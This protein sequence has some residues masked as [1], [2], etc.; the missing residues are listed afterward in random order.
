MSWTAAAR[1]PGCVTHLGSEQAPGAREGYRLEGA[2]TSYLG[3]FCIR[4]L[5]CTLGILRFAEISVFVL[6]VV[7]SYIALQSEFLIEATC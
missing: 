2:F 6:G 1:W 3:C 7:W 4:A 5:F